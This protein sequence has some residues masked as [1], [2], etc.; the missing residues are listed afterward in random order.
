MRKELE[1]PTV[2]AIKKGSIFKSNAVAK[3]TATGA[4]TTAVAALFMMSDNVIVTTNKIPR[5]TPG[6][7]APAKCNKPFTIRSVPPEVCNA[8]PTG[9]IAANKT[10]TDQSMSL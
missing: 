6:G 9:I 3:L 1:E 4:I 5:I 8:P 2:T 7:I 10:M